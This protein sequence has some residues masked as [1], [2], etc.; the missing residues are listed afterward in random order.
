MGIFAAWAFAVFLYFKVAFDAAFQYQNISVVASLLMGAI[1]GFFVFFLSGQYYL[2]LNKYN[3]NP[4][5]F[6]ATFWNL[7]SITIWQFLGS[8]I[9]YIVI[10]RLIVFGF[11]KELNRA[12]ERGDVLTEELVLFVCLSVLPVLVH[13]I[14]TLWPTYQNCA[15]EAEKNQ[16]SVDTHS[17]C[18]SGNQT[19]DPQYKPDNSYGITQNTDG[20]F[21]YKDFR[22]DKYKDALNYAQIKSGNYTHYNA[23][24]NK[25]EGAAYNPEDF[26][27]DITRSIKKSDPN[28]CVMLLVAYVNLDALIETF[29]KYDGVPKDIDACIM[30]LKEMRQNKAGPNNTSEEIKKRRVTWFYM[31]A[32]VKKATLIAENNKDVENQ[33]AEMWV[34]IAEATRCLRGAL[35]ENII[36]STT[37]KEWFS[38]IEKEKDGPEYCINIVLP[39]WLRC[40]QVIRNYAHKYDLFVTY[41][42][43]ASDISQAIKPEEPS[44]HVKEV[45]KWL[46]ENVV[47]FKDI[48]SL[49]MR[50]FTVDWEK[51]NGTFKVTI[52]PVMGYR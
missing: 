1:F 28:S 20:T 7:V 16:E 34:H 13:Y 2:K 10:S 38:G 27:N 48:K 42:S 6:Q 26:V 24:G 15:P 30:M 50:D 31:S 41:K 40:N 49:T 3:T 25:L 14:M 47:V 8:A 51:L 52:T 45:F 35:D 44:E 21:Q 33:V 12:L 5:Q 19:N 37:E 29:E 18:V 43:E 9:A 17:A 46:E 23:N 39:D 4:N 32:I 22:Y 11:S 36:W